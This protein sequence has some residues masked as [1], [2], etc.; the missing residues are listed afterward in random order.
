MRAKIEPD[1]E[2]YSKSDETGSAGCVL[3]LLGGIGKGTMNGIWSNRGNGNEH[4][5]VSW[6]LTE[7]SCGDTLRLRVS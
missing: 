7:A 3:R 1:F 6:G 5:Q 4:L 2:G